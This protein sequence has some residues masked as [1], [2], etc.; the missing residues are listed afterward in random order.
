MSAQ[1][2]YNYNITP[3]ESFTPVLA[4]GLSL[5]ASLLRSPGLFSV[6]RPISTMEGLG[7]SSDF[8]LFQPPF[9]AF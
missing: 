1:I 2:D 7:S 5:K 4:D 3:Y 9:Q 6:F 8:Q